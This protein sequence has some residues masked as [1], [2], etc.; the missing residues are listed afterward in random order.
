MTVTVTVL[1]LVTGAVLGTA[2]LLVQLTE[3]VFALRSWDAIG[4]FRRF[5][6]LLGPLSVA[7]RMPRAVLVGMLG[8]MAATCAGARVCC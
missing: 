2:A 5:G 6:G 4:W 3:A 8:W 7:V 1:V